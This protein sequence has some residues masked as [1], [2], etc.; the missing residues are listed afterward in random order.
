MMAVPAKQVRLGLQRCDLDELRREVLA[1]QYSNMHVMWPVLSGMDSRA[2][3]KYVYVVA[4]G[5]LPADGK[6]RW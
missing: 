6:K 3:Q 1:G 2:P 5:T 4:S